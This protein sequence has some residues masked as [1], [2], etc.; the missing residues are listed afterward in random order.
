MAFTAIAPL[1]V[2]AYLHSLRQVIAYISKSLSFTNVLQSI[3]R[4]NHRSDLAV[5]DLV[6]NWPRFLRNPHTRTLPLR[7]FHPLA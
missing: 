7:A 6:C 2:L 4:G 1:A 3:I 5:S